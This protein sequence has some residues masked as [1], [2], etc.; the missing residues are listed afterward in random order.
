MRPEARCPRE[1]RGPR[2]APRL[3]EAPCH[4]VGASPR[5]ARSPR[6][7]PHRRAGVPRGAPQGEVIRGLPARRH[8]RPAPAARVRWAGRRIRCHLQDS[9]CSSPSWPAAASGEGDAFPREQVSA[10][11]N[12]DIPDIPSRICNTPEIAGG[13]GRPGVSWTAGREAPHDSSRLETTLKKRGSAFSAS[14]RC[15]GPGTRY[16]SHS[17]RRSIAPGAIGIPHFREIV[18]IWERAGPIAPVPR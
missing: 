2:V 7:A 6:A 13:S 10:A 16:G 18:S 4:R 12:H 1:A 15:F 8:G 5:A 9:S 11:A 3:R 14:G 17:L